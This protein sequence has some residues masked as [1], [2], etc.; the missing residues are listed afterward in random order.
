M[1]KQ[2]LGTGFCWM[3]LYWGS[4]QCDC[5]KCVQ[6]LFCE[7]VMNNEGAVFRDRLLLDIIVF[8]VCSV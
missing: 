8:G 7:G 5:T 4:V 3:Y 6:V 2:C 1:M